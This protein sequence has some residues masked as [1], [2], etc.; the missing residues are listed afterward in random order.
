MDQDIIKLTKSH[1]D[2]Y[3][4]FICEIEK[5]YKWTFLQTRNRLTDIENKLIVTKAESGGEGQQ[6]KRIR[7]LGLTNTHY[8]I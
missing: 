1:K 6:E 5:S 8:N 2:K 4:S 7:N 3:I